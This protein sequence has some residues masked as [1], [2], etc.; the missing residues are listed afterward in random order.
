[1]TRLYARLARANMMLERERDNKLMN[2]QAITATIAH[3]VRQPLAAIAINASA[4]L[5]FLGRTP[6][7]PDEVRAALERIKNESH[8]TKA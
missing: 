8:R 1:M 5:R 2:A 3:E 6:L 4:A 7:D